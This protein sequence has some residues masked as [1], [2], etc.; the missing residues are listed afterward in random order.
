MIRFGLKEHGTDIKTELIAGMSTFLAMLYIVPVNASILSTTGMP[1][2]ALVTATALITIIATLINA[3]WSNTPVAMSVGMGLNT[4]FAFGMVKGMGMSWQSALGVQVVSA[5]LYVLISLTPLR[6]WIVRSIPLDIKRA[7]SASIGAF[8]AFIGF[9]EMHII[10][11]DSAT[12]VTLGD[13]RS[14]QIILG[15]F[16]MILGIFLLLKKVRAAF[17]ISMI[18]TAALAWIFRIAPLPDR[19]VSMPASLAP[20]FAKM[21]IPSVLTLSAL[22]VI[23]TFLVTDIFDTLGTLTGLGLR[24]GFFRREHSPELER[25][26]QADAVGTFLSGLFG[27]TSTTPFVENAAGVEAGGRTGLTAVVVA[28]LFLFPLFFLPFFKAIPSFAI[29]PVLILIGAMMF[30]ELKGINYDDPAVLYSTFFMILGMPLSYSIT[31]GLLMGALV[32]V[33]VRAFQGRFLENRGMVF[34]ATIGVVLF[35]IL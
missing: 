31:D 30:S 16:G 19:V 6:S 1:F 5:T 35:F 12:L 4:F 8:I 26:I 27:V 21:D 28:L 2:D 11:K 3:F 25:S 32:Y 18:S 13:L 9:Q 10:V 34:L 24:A 7:V 14:P 17:I 29:Y 23:L 20:I 15:L 33:I 22:P